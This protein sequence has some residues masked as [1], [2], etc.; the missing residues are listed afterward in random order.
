[1]A[2]TAMPMAEAP[3]GGGQGGGDA[4]AMTA[5]ATGRH[6]CGTIVDG[7]GTGA[8]PLPDRSAATEIDAVL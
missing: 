6:T 7:R 1:M 3:F 8:L 4:S 2:S 5:T